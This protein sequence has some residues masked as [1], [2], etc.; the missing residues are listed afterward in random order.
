[1]HGVTPHLRIG[2]SDSISLCC[3]PHMIHKLLPLTSSLSMYT[4]NTPA[5][6][7]MLLNKKIDIAIATDP[8]LKQKD[9]RALHLHNEDFL[10]VAPKKYE[11]KI[12]HMTDMLRLIQDLPVIRFN[13]LSLDAIQIERVLRQCNVYSPH[14]IEADTNQTVLSLISQGCGWSVM[15]TLGLWAAKDFLPNVSI[16]KLHSLQAKRVAYVLYSSSYYEP[17]AEKVKSF[18]RE[19]ITEI[20]IPKMHQVNPMLVHSISILE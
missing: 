6:C 7:E 4:F 18:I 20:V 12:K 14:L 19:T 2:T 11:G 15:P 5:V 16:H 13:D 8:L 10:I 9:I 1:M 17:I 3:V